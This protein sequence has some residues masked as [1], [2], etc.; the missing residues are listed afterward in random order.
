MTDP[1][2]TFFPRVHA[3]RCDRLCTLRMRKVSGSKRQAR[4]WNGLR[5]EKKDGAGKASLLVVQAERRFMLGTHLPCYISQL[6]HKSGL[7]DFREES[8][9]NKTQQ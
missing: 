8:E 7:L 6:T 9:C 3:A 4:F 1:T 2:Y 5:H